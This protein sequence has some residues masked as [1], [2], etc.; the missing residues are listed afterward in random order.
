MRDATREDVTANDIEGNS[1]DKLLNKPA[2]RKP[3]AQKIYKTAGGSPEEPLK[4]AAAST[5]LRMIQRLRKKT[6]KASEPDFCDLYPY[7]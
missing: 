1:L 5:P 7:F 2:I 3:A 6:R 4:D